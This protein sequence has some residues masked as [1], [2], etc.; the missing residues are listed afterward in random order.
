[1]K[2]CVLV[3]VL[4][5]AAL[6]VTADEGMWLPEQLPAVA[7]RM[8]AAG[9][10]GDPARFA[11]LTADPMAA[12]V[13]LGGCS[14]SFVSPQ[15]LVATNH[16]CAYGSIQFNSTEERNLLAEGFLAR[17]LEDELPASPGARIYV[18]EKVEDVTGKVLHGIPEDADGA[19]R[20]DAIEEAEKRLVRA[21]EEQPH[22]R[23]TVAAF[24]GGLEYRLYTR[25]EIR[26][27]RLVYAP[28]SSIGNYGDDVDNWMWPRHT[29]DFSFYRAWVGPDGEPADRAP[30]N[31][32]YRPEHWLRVGADGVDE[33]DFVMVVGFPGSTNRYRL[34]S[35]VEEAIEHVYPDR[36]ESRTEDLNIIERETAGDTAA[37]LAYAASVSYLNNGLKNS[38]GMVAGF[39]R[40]GT[41]E[42]KR[43]LESEL[44]AW[45]EA[46]P[47]RRSRWGSAI[48]D[49]EEVLEEKAATR[50]RDQFQGTMR[51]SQM[52]STA[53]TAY[54]LATERERPD[55]DRSPGYQERDM[56][57]LVGRQARM[58][59]SF[60]PHVD[61]ALTQRMLE[62]YAALPVEARL[63]ALDE[64]FGLNDTDDAASAIA[65]KLRA[66]YRDTALTNP[67]ERMA[68]FQNDLAAL[69]TSDDPM[70]V[71]A[72]A[73]Y[74]TT[75]ALE[76]EREAM[77]GR[78]AAARPP[79]IEALLA[80]EKDRGRVLYP[81]ANG[82]LRVT[83][84]T[85][86]GYAPR[87]AVHYSAF[88]TAEGV[89]EKATGVEPFDASARLLEAIAEGDYGPYAS[90]QLGTLPVNF[91]SSVDTTGGN[92]GSATLDAEGRFVGLLFD[93]NW[94][95]LVSDWDFLPDV[96]RSI[97]CDVRYTLWVMDRIDGA[98][99]LLEEMGVE[100]AFKP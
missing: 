39:R 36:I 18:I 66:M 98:W 67:A 19:T 91:L 93:G 28:P 85:V 88:T 74:E 81:D 96:T 46:D 6:G 33:G 57:R 79:V 82:T 87:D 8:A 100:P 24:H 52:L 4:M 51:R 32:P 58:A 55:D 53:T 48:A 49:L 3:G 23:C 62:R 25:L 86:Q 14:A 95:S 40:S 71:F 69:N 21:C 75:L 9:F 59:R 47:A 76:N 35:E 78:L 77:D 11:E 22:R 54:R 38:Q 13:S 73:M 26:D 50:E 29:G 30:E 41:V 44:Q 97:H 16:H 5:L 94:E 89:A 83:F 68:V 10:E 17:S 7:E 65:A 42:R 34:A 70:I 12:I 2:H 99:N 90:E 43:A 63:P 37:E 20:H 15:G 45:I 80:F 61:R 72:R 64:W 27:V 31:V 1:M 56:A 92:S 84:G 60:V